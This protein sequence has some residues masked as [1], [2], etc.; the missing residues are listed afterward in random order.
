VCSSERTQL[1][2]ETLLGLYLNGLVGCYEYLL[3]AALRR[4]GERNGGKKKRIAAKIAAKEVQRE[5][6]RK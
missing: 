5:E 6:R 3:D 2:I 1:A 4:S